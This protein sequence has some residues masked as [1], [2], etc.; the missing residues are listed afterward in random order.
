MYTAPKLK[1]CVVKEGLPFPP[2]AI[3]DADAAASALRK[4]AYG[5]NTIELYESFFVLALNRANQVLGC[6]KI[7]QG[8]TAGTVVDAKI[9]FASALMVPGC[10]SL[11][12]CHNHPS[13]S[14]TPSEA[15]ISLTRK[16]CKA[17]EMLDIK[18]LDHLILSENGHV[19]LANEGY[20]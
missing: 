11:V 1:L 13:G 8:G 17:G 12:L 5:D 4:L 18:I 6:F 20:I 9:V 7:S 3:N 14:L 16:L 19:S 2:Y 10:C 15:D